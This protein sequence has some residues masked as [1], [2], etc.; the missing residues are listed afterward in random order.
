M[1]RC[2]LHNHMGSPKLENQYRVGGRCLTMELISPKL[3]TF[4]KIYL[5]HWKPWTWGHTHVPS[6]SLQQQRYTKY[7]RKVV[8]SLSKAKLSNERTVTS[9]LLS[10]W[11]L[12]LELEHA[13]R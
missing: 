9:L 3:T 12:Q 7:V 13:N 6:P 10:R 1:V 4:A 8:V 2:N 11:K 5:V